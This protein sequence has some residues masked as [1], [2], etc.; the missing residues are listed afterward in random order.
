MAAWA[1]EA[2]TVTGTKTRLAVSRLQVV[3]EH[4]VGVAGL[5]P[6]DPGQGLDN[7]QVVEAQKTLHDGGDVAGVADGHHHGFVRQIIVEG[8]GDLIGIGLLAPDAPGVFGVEQGHLVVVGQG[9]HHLHAVV[10]DA[11]DL[12]DLGA[13]A[14][15]LGQ[16]LG[17]DLAVGQDHRGGDPVSQVGGVKRRRRG[18]VA[19]G[20]ADGQDLA[21]PGLLRQEVEVAQGRG[22]AP[23]LERGAGVL[24]VVLEIKGR[25]HLVLQVGVGRHLGG[26]AFPQVDDV[27]QRN[28]RG[29]EFVVP[30]NT[31]QGREVEHAAVIEE[32]APEGP[33]FLGQGRG[34]FILQ[35]EQTPAVGGRC[36]GAR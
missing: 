1:T 6:D 35:H 30:E 4:R 17:R 22:H 9:L 29:D 15:G 11:G 3:A 26:V 12:Q 13:A 27:R 28:H 7:L 14:Q 10:E 32:A 16:L 36:R 18:G 23:V 24:A 8:L 20:G 2:C 19:G 31:A 5:D 25:A 33:G 21:G 34:V